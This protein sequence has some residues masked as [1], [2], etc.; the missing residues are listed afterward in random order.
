MTE[1]TGTQRTVS[2]SPE[3]RRA[4]RR[5]PWPGNVRELMNRVQRAVLIGAG[6]EV[7]EEDLGLGAPLEAPEAGPAPSSRAAEDDR[8]L[9][10]AGSG[11]PSAE[12]S[13]I[14]EALVTARGNVS[15][16]AASLGV[17][18]Q[19]LYRRMARLGIVMERRPRDE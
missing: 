15:D 17:S 4:L 14:Q 9:A 12:R 13:R 18:R 16:A 6:D 10:A 11:G 1:S 3:A 5:H 8:D 2:F 19:A 7:S